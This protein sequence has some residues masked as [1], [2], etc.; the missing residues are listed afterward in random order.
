MFD[1]ERSIWINLRAK[2]ELGHVNVSFLLFRPGNKV[3][4]DFGCGDAKIARNV[5]H[6]VHSFD[7]VALNDHVTACD[8]A[9]VSFEQVHVQIMVHVYSLTMPNQDLKKKFKK[10][11]KY[12]LYTCSLFIF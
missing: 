6:K 7:L 9:H 3:V 2:E 11:L 8:M 5:P 4:A 12:V 1:S 10:I